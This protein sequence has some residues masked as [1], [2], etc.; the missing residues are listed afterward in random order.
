MASKGGQPGN[1][2]ATKN[3]PFQQALERALA[4]KGKV[5]QAEALLDVANA[6]IC[7]AE[8]G[9]MQ[10]IK[11]LADRLDGKAVQQLDIDANVTMTHEEWLKTLS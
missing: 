9:D 3:K 11:E 2:N 7:A 1:K 4:K 10:A 6:L 8:G 5:D